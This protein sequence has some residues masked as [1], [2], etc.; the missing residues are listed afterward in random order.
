MTLTNSEYSEF[1]NFFVVGN[2]ETDTPLLCR[3][4]LE[5]DKDTCA[6]ANYTQMKY[7]TPSQTI[8]SLCWGLISCFCTQ[9]PVC[10]TTPPP[11]ENKHVRR[12]ILL[13]NPIFV[14]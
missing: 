13:P 3:I 12:T 1:S 11:R 9:S 8:Y 2:T 14:S 6:T 10:G 5:T 4:D 7:Q